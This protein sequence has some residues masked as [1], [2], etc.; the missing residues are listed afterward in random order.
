MSFILVHFAVLP[1]YLAAAAPSSFGYFGNDMII[2]AGM[3]HNMETSSTTR[4]DLECDNA[5]RVITIA[6]LPLASL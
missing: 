4:T 1:F 3:S 2:M 5:W 6:V